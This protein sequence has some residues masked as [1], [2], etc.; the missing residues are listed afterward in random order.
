MER[1]D[2]LKETQRIIR[3]QVL[4]TIDV[5]RIDTLITNRM[6]LLREI[7]AIVQRISQATNRYLSKEDTEKLSHAI[8]DEILGFG[9]M[10]ELLEDETVNDILVNGPDNIFVERRGKLEKTKLTFLDN[11]QLTDIAK[12]LVARVGRRID[13]SQPLVDARLHD[14]S[15]LNV[16]INPIALDGTSIS[17]R[18]FSKISKTFKDL[19]NYGTLDE[20]L[21]NLLIVAAK[22]RINIVISG[23]T[24]SGKT[25]LMNALSQHISLDERIITLEDAAELRLLQPHVVRLETKMASIENTGKVTMR[26]LVINALRMRPDRIIIG[27]C[28]GEET[29]EMLQAMNTG[30]DGSMTTLH[31]NTPR[32]AI[33]RLENMVMMAGLSL[34]VEVIR[35]NIASAVNI[36]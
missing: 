31:A 18:K 32:D 33:A 1:S 36:L 29:F 11:E 26:N 6:A 9:P 2:E 16:V 8:T 24:G 7:I 19:I 12:R 28:R 35:R 10:R 25:T 30:H 20:K 17:I 34:P 4:D 5:D 22:C 21:A 23:G 14:G 3:Q 13:E 15:R 27:E